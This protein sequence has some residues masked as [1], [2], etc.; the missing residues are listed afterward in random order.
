MI[1]HYC[2]EFRR[3]NESEFRGDYE[4]RLALV[5]AHTAS[6]AITQFTTEQA[7]LRV[8]R[9]FP[10]EGT[11]CQRC[12]GPIYDDQEIY[13]GQNRYPPNAYATPT[14]ISVAVHHA[15][16]DQGTVTP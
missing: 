6:D 3:T 7:G 9:I 1:R 4:S 14:E 5:R 10:V 13:I 15:C 8:A 11:R 16:P 2:I 12:R